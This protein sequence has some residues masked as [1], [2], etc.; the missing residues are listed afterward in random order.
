MLRVS[1]SSSPQVYAKKRSQNKWL[2]FTP[3]ASNMFNHFSPEK[4][5]FKTCHKFCTICRAFFCQNLHVSDVPPPRGSR[6]SCNHPTNGTLKRSREGGDENLVF[7]SAQ[8]SA[9]T[10]FK[11]LLGVQSRNNEF[12]LWNDVRAQYRIA[13]KKICNTILK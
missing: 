7:Y 10:L 11:S 4:M 5:F 1:V 3:V 9:K 8:W 12:I 2:C 13:R 6:S